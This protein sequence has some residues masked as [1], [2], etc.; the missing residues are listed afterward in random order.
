VTPA[1]KRSKRPHR[2]ERASAQQARAAEP[3]TS[4]RVYPEWRWR[5]FPVFAAFVLGL[6]IASI[7]SG[8]P[9]NDVAAMVQIAALL[10]V[11]YVIA[12]MF[13]MNVIIAGRLRRRQQAID[14]GETPPDEVEDVAVY[15]DDEDA[16][17]KR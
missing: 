13:V 11:G 14:R 4:R 7:I 12:H 8:A 15:P 16:G 6:L 3:E 10:G 1:K 2:L 5:T 9:S 17:A